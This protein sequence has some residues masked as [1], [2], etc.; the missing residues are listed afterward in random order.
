MRLSQASIA[1]L[2]V[3]T[4]AGCNDPGEGARFENARIDAEQT[5]QAIEAFRKD[6]GVYPYSLDVLAPAQLS[7]KFLAKHRPGGD[8]GFFYGRTVEGGFEFWFKYT[9][10]GMNRCTWTGLPGAAAW[11]CTGHI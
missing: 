8:V 6:H 7:S 1:L 2:V 3:C 10:A 9:D 4:L 11:E 5:I